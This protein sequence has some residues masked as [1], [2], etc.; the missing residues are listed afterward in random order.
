M[1]DRIAGA[2][3]DAPSQ[4]AQVGASAAS[5][6]GWV[7]PKGLLML[8]AL[9]VLFLTPREMATDRNGAFHLMP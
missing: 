6:E 1:S 4:T 2:L 9:T 3:L 7:H 8:H 5:G